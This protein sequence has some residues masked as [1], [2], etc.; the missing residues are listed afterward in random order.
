MKKL[1]LFLFLGL[2][3]GQILFGMEQ[4]V[5]TLDQ[6]LPAANRV[7]KTYN[8]AEAT[9]AGLGIILDRIDPAQTMDAQDKVRR[10]MD[11]LFAQTNNVEDTVIYEALEGVANELNA[12]VNFPEKEPAVEEAVQDVPECGICQQELGAEN[13]DGP[14]ECTHEFHKNCIA[15]WAGKC[16]MCRAQRKASRAAA[17]PAQ[18]AQPAQAVQAVQAVAQLSQSQANHGL[19]ESAAHARLGG[20]D[21]FIA[22]GADVN[23]TDPNDPSKRTALHTASLW[24]NLEIVDRLLAYG[25]DINATDRVGYTALQVA[26]AKNHLEIVDR[27]LAYG[28]DVNAG[29]NNFGDITQRIRDRIEQRIDILHQA[30]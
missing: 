17:Q 22:A 9:G 3:T 21:R 24:G 13:L 23:A 2:F 15:Q 4:E 19:I 28:A 27:L 29:A 26:A 8:Q 7:D 30:A 11:Q 10:A 1:N 14:Y 12:Q 6:Y 20:V 18:P 25:A 5:V 16:P